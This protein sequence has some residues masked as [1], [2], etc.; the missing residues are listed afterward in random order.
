VPTN[1]AGVSPPVLFSGRKKL[2]VSPFA[3]ADFPLLHLPL[4]CVLTSASD[5]K[6]VCRY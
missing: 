6:R 5:D 3:T 4:Y 2:W 1:R